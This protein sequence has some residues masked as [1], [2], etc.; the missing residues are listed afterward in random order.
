MA[1]IRAMSAAWETPEAGA[2]GAVS[3]VLMGLVYY[4]VW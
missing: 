1:F 2:D 3:V 4:L